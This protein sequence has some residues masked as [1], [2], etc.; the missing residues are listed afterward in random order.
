MWIAHGFILLIV[1]SM[2]LSMVAHPPPTLPK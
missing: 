2:F 1:I